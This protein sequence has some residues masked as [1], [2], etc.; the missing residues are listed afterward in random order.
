LRILSI[1]PSEKKIFDYIGIEHDLFSRWGENKR[2]GKSGK[3][4]IRLIIAHKE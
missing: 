3:K 2:I 4:K 1:K